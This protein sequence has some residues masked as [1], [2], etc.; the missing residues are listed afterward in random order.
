MNSSGAKPAYSRRVVLLTLMTTHVALTGGG[1]VVVK[2]ALREFAPAALGFWRL[3]IGLGGLSMVIWLGRAWPRVEKSDW[4]R[5][6]LLSLVAVP[7]NQLVYLVGMSKTMPSHAALLYGTTAVFALFLSSALGYERIVRHKIIAIVVSLSGLT[8]VVT[9]GG[10]FSLNSDIF[11]GDL[12]IFAAVLAWATY[13]VLGKPLVTKYGAIPTT[14]VI[15]VIGTIFSL[16]FLLSPA[17]GQDYSK[18][19]WI[20]WGGAFYTGIFLTVVA[21]FVWYKI[22]NLVDPSQ[23]A[24]L[25]TPQPVLATYLSSIFVGE[26]IGWPLVVGGLMIITGIV[27]MDA[28]AFRRRADALMQRVT[29]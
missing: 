11:I 29:G 21:Y 5:I 13:T 19:T 22:L 10:N 2:L 16:P 6:L 15:L 8:L 7:I 4:P 18:I 14:C 12:L 3:L 27:L 24:I 23:V 26:I 28:P 25:T 9:R 20:G 1:Y 17:L